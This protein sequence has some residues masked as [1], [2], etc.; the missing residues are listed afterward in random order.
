MR[1]IEADT[2]LGIRVE[3][4]YCNKCDI[5]LTERGVIED[6]VEKISSKKT[7]LVSQLRYKGAAS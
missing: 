5:S 1:Q 4:H 2:G 6:M 7:F 3:S